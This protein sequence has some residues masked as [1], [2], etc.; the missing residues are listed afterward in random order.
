MSTL[1]TASSL[2]GVALK[3]P[4]SL[5]SRLLYETS[6]RA[7]IASRVVFLLTLILVPSVQAQTLRVWGADRSGQV[8][9]APEGNFKAIA[10]GSF[11]GLALRTNGT[12]VLWGSGPAGVMLP[13]PPEIANDHFRA[14][15][16]GRDDAILVRTNWTLVHYGRNPVMDN[17]SPGSFVEVA[18]A[19]VHAVAISQ[20]GTLKAFGSDVYPPSSGPLAGTPGEIITGLTN[21]PNRGPFEA[22]ESVVTGSLALRRDGLLFGWGRPAFEFDAAGGWLPTPG[23]PAIYYIPGD[24]FKAIAGGNIHAIAVR[25]DG[26]VTGWGNSLAKAGGAIV[27]PSNVRFEQVAAGWGFSV[28]LSTDGTLWGWGTPFAHPASE[29]WSFAS[30]G[31]TRCG[32]CAEEHYYVSGERFKT[33]AA[34]AFHIMAITRGKGGRNR[35]DD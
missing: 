2:S 35:D 28:G 30:E 14:I 32:A 16:L 1:K 15:S 22:V 10:G 21:A 19:A 8:S 12:P 29:A 7:S 3:S 9:M 11:E 6:M 31:W 13:F 4:L 20:D 33:V 34:G 27:A 26:T 24:T 23:N 25:W 17:V 18:V 5:V